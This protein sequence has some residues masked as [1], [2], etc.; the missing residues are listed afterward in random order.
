MTSTALPEQLQPN[1]DLAF[2]LQWESLAR[3]S[4]DYTVFV[5][6]VN[7]EGVNVAQQDQPPLAG[8]APTRLWEP[9]LHYRDE[10]HLP[11][12]ADLLPGA[13]SVRI[14]LY[15]LDG[16]RLPVLQNEAVIGD[17]ATLGTF[18]VTAPGSQ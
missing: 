3:T 11:L 7:T 12:P 9:G 13:Y 16:G 10:Y 1:A 15:T 2:T 5:H 6:V 14:G 17:F 4:T 8:F 18:T